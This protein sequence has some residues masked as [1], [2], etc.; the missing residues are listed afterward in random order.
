M[1]NVNISVVE[2]M[3]AALRARRVTCNCAA[4]T[5]LAQPGRAPA[6]RR[7]ALAAQKIR[8]KHTRKFYSCYKN[9]GFKRGLDCFVYLQNITPVL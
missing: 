6:P 1:F 7:A 3:R 2:G 4:V 8:S 5:K 9:I